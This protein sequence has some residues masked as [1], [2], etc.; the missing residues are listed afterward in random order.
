MTADSVQVSCR[1]VCR[2]F[3]HSGSSTKCKWLAPQHVV[4]HGHSQMMVL[5]IDHTVKCSAHVNSTTNSLTEISYELADWA[6]HRTVL[7]KNTMC[8]ILLR[9]ASKFCTFT[10]VELEPHTVFV[11]AGALAPPRWPVAQRRRHSDIFFVQASV[12]RSTRSL[13]D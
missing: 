9:D 6:V 11:S 10:E 12:Y 7:C 13:T 3:S 2:M 1:R 8:R 5:S 4:F